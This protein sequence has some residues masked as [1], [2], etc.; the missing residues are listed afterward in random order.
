MSDGAAASLPRGVARAVMPEELRRDV[1]LLGNALGRVIAENEGRELIERVEDLRSAAFAF[2]DAAGP[3]TRDRLERTVDGLSE[4]Q[5]AVVVR[6]F[7]L[8]FQLVNLAEQ[9]HRIRVLRKRGA[10]DAPVDDSLADGVLSVRSEDGEEALRSVVAKLEIRPVLTAHPTESRRRSVQEGLQRV[11]SHLAVFDDPRTSRAEDARARTGLLEAVAALWRTDPIRRHRPT[12]LDE[13]RGA[14]IAFDESMFR[15]VPLLYREMDRVLGGEDDLGRRPPLFHAFLRWGSWIGGDRDGNPNVTA[16]VTRETLGVHTDH[17]LRGLEAATRRIGRSLTASDGAVPPSPELLESLKADERRSPVLG[18]ALRAQIPDQPYRRKMM[19]VLE[20]LRA[21]REGRPGGYASADRFL[22][23]LRLVQGALA[24]GGAERL[25]YG[26]L[27]HLIWQAETFGFHLASLEIRQHSEV[28]DQVL[29]ELVPGAAGDAAALDRIAREGADR[30][31][32]LSEVA[33]EVLETF[34]AVSDLQRRYGPEAC[35]RYVVS[36]TRSAADVAG[37][38][39]LARL[40]VPEDPPELDVVPLFESR[41]DLERAVD[42]LE[43]VIGLPGCAADLDRAGRRLRVMLGYSDSAKDAGFLAGNVAIHRAQAALAAWSR[44]R[45]IRLTLFH[46]RGGALGRGGGPTNRAIRGQAAGSVDGRFD[47]TEQGEV[48]FERYGLL[49][50]AA[51]H[52]E[53]V[54]G[55]VVQASAPSGERVASACLERYGDVLDAMARASE[56][57]YRALVDAEGFADF[58]DRVTPIGLIETM[59]IGSR[60]ARRSGSRDLDSLRAIPWVFSWSQIRCTV[61]GWFG[62]GAGLTEV[63]SSEGLRALEDMYRGWPFFTSLV[64]SAELSL[65][66]T[67]MAVA[68]A[69]LELGGDRVLAERIADEYERT[70]TM[71]LRLTGQERLLEHRGLHGAAVVMRSPYVDVLSFVQLGALRRLQALPP[72]DPS[73]AGL[74]RLVMLSIEGVAAGLQTAG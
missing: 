46:G 28:H 63:E 54:T 24:G 65:A 68:R 44:S 58:F 39:A 16:E 35:R 40:A 15:V 2:R 27:Q 38:R 66:R 41:E 45:D 22:R 18:E 37:V 50:L 25:A 7:T 47:V 59:R 55:A 36:F 62:F 14:M 34:R 19:L 71:L 56:A 53:Q 4:D 67:D 9:Q 32:G 33:Q 31:S 17:L 69:Y 57:A 29:R 11:A 26:E 60:P 48:I 3:Q 20:R 42:V 52:L 72:D 13:V 49:P 1:R 74:D 6:A 64:D 12:P 30:V 5:A 51:R 21:T 73:R 8:Y 10:G 43:E 70:Q 61:P 23:D